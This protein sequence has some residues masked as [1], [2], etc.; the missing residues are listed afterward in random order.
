MISFS[1]INFLKNYIPN[2]EIKPKKEKLLNKNDILLIFPTFAYESPNKVNAVVSVEGK[3]YKPEKKPLLRKLALEVLEDLAGLDVNDDN[4]D[5]STFNDRM[6]KFIV[7]DESNVPVKLKILGTTKTFSTDIKGHFKGSITIKKSK[8]KDSQIFPEVLNHPNP[9]NIIANKITLIPNNGIAVISDIDDTIRITNM[10]NSKEMIA[11]AFFYPFRPIPGMSDLYSYMKDKA[12]NFFYVSATFSQ[13]LV[14][15]IS[16]LE[17]NNY[18][19]GQ[20]FMKFVSFD[21]LSFFSHATD[22]PTSIKPPYLEEIWTTFQQK[23]FI[24]IGDDGESDPEIYG[25]FARKH[26]DSVVGIFIHHMDPFAIIDDERFK[27][28]FRDLP[29]IAYVFK[30]PEEL[31][32][33]VNKI[34]SR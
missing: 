24:V 31:Y 30:D 14:P 6:D 26:P 22:A 32:P 29:D 34:L 23:K 5:L 28:A 17:D 21:D 25:D 20:F 4:M 16:F 13:F 9:K 27:V 15:L 2:V 19:I 11:N 8:I 33:L 3:V 10:K 18:P 7:D 1:D 12:I